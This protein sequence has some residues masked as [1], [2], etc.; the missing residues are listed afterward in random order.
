MFE[1]H[2]YICIIIRYMWVPPLKRGRLSYQL[3]KL[4]DEKES[5][6]FVV[7]ATFFSGLVSTT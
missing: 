3:N 4:Y 7:I 2:K 6:C 5:Y 1:K